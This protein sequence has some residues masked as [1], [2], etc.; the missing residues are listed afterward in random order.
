MNNKQ[1]IEQLKAAKARLQRAKKALA[2]A[3]EH[4]QSSTA[5]QLLQAAFK[6]GWTHT[7]SISMYD[8][9]LKD[10]KPNIHNPALKGFRDGWKQS[11]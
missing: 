4:K 8:E 9:I 3:E 11:V 10:K 1:L 7:S 2:E 6:A 5:K